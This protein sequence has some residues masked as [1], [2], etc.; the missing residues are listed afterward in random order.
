M[1]KAVH[2]LNNQLAVILNYANFVIEDSEVYPSQPSV[3]LDGIKGA[4]FTAAMAFEIGSTNLVVEL[5]IILALFVPALPG[6]GA[7]ETFQNTIARLR[8]PD[9]CPWDREQTHRT[10]TRHLL[11]ETYEVLEAIEALPLD[12]EAEDAREGFDHLEEEL[13]DLL[14][15]VVFH[16]TLGAGAFLNFNCIILD[17]DEEIAFH[18]E[19]PTSDAVRGRTGATSSRPP[20]PVRIGA[21][22]RSSSDLDIFGLGALALGMVSVS[23][24]GLLLGCR[25][26]IGAVLIAF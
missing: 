15:Q 9:G 12:V 23:R 5:G 10:L 13:G 21:V 20:P 16:A 6:P 3:M 4:N 14:F 1:R 19:Q 26:F 2:D 7:F 24:P 18:L 8:A 11:E 25:M 22:L 17:V